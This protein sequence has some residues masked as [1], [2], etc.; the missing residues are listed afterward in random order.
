MGITNFDAFDISINSQSKYFWSKYQC[1][2]SNTIPMEIKDNARQFETTTAQGLVG[3][4]L[5]SRRKYSHQNTRSRWLRR[6]GIPY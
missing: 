2:S 5:L 3:R 4:I 1:S 6:R